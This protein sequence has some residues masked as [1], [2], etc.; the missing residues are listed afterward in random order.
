MVVIAQ[1]LVE[2]GLLASLGASLQ[3]QWNRAV[4]LTSQWDQGTWAALGGAALLVLVLWSRR[5][6]RF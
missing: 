4:T 1:N 3:H 5:T 6:S 2:Y